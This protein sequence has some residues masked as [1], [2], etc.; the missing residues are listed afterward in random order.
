MYG[1]IQLSAQ[2]RGNEYKSNIN[3]T[4]Y[5]VRNYFFTNR[6]IVNVWNSLQYTMVTTDTINQFKN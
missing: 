4:K 6:N 5:D 3:R 1:L 2:K